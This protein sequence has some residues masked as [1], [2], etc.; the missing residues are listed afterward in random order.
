MLIGLQCEH[1]GVAWMHLLGYTC[2]AFYHVCRFFEVQVQEAGGREIRC[3]AYGC[4]RVVPNV[5]VCMCG[6]M[7]EVWVCRCG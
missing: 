3:P 6:W 2:S 5:R 1:V 4:F 7:H